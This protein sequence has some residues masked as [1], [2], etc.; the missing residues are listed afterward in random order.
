[1]KYK[2]LSLI[3][4]LFFAVFFIAGCSFNGGEV[5]T[6]AVGEFDNAPNWVQTQQLPHKISG[7]GG[8]KKGKLNFRAQRDEAIKNA[9]EDLSKKLRTKTLR[10]FKLLS[11]TSID[12]KLYEEDVKNATDEIVKNA[13]AHA[14]VMKLW[15]SNAKS[16]YVLVSTDI[17]KIKYDFKVLVT[18]TFK[19]IPTVS[20]NYELKLEQGI[21]DAQLRD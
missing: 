15:Q 7:F 5:K 1:M 13:S 16:I 18:T 20:S 4:P 8:A 19:D 6:T 10:I 3:L 14:K 9:Q 2:Y 11:D 17:Q 12:K 21:I